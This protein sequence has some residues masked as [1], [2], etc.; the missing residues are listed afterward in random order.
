M[1]RCRASNLS[2]V[3]E[4]RWSSLT[5]LLG[6][7]NDLAFSGG[8]FVLLLDWWPAVPSR[9]LSVLKMQCAPLG[10]EMS[11]VGRLWLSGEEAYMKGGGSGGALK[12]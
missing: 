7:E 5:F 3:R 10:S 9:S 2:L 11:P 1:R 4:L 6:C 12:G 8:L